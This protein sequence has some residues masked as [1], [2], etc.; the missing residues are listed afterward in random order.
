MI[1]TNGKT[2][3]CPQ[4]LVCT[5][6][7]I[8]CLLSVEQDEQDEKLIVSGNKCLRGEKHAINEI[9]APK[10]MVTSTVKIVGGLYPVIP[11]KTVEPVFKEKIFI[12]MNI[13]SDVE[14]KAPVRTGDVIISD[15]VGTGVDI[16][17]T[18]SSSNK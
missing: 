1:T 8:G 15:V 16:V 7:P 11:V 5:C 2:K 14:I 9:I 17:A 3:K 18:K 4:E 13:L 12:I 10:R 6:C